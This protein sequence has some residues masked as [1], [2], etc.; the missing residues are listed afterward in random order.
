MKILL[1]NDDGI[2][3]PGLR[4][5]GD[6]LR[7]AGH[8]VVVVAPDREQSASSHSITLD[9]PLRIRTIEDDIHTVDGT[10]TDCV[11]VGCHGL[12]KCHPDLVV[13]GI[14]HG[15]NLGED[16]TYSGTVA[17][18]FEAHIL[19]IPS[20]AASMKDRETGDYAGAGDVVARLA[21]RFAE[22]A[23][24]RR[25][26]LNV[27]FPPGPASGWS[28]PTVTRLGTRAYS[29]EI[30]EKEDP[31]GKKYYWIGGADPVWE[32]GDDTDSAAVHSG[33]ISVTPLHLDIT[34]EATRVAM[35]SFDM[36]GVRA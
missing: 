23:D 11:L 21:G 2:L 33:A 35:E 24:G 1:T 30:I 9:R 15:P 18:A 8:R 3:A 36:R 26:V 25:I 22:W 17:A 16:V 19:G 27:N 12:L 5:L 28:G 29:D 34:D 20:I 10:P 4:L 32:E 6:S 14:N 7:A 13:S 31:R